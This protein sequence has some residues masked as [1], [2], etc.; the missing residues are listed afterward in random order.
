MERLEKKRMVKSNDFM[1]LAVGNIS[2]REGQDRTFIHPERTF[3]SSNP[4]PKRYWKSSRRR[5]S[6][7]SQILQLPRILPEL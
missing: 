4:R 2:D 6:R 7:R 3:F 5:K 1:T